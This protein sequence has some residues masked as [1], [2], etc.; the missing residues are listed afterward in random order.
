MNLP[1]P[2]Q[3]QRA[4]VGLQDIHKR[5][6]AVHEVWI[7]KTEHYTDHNKAVWLSGL[8][9]YKE[10]VVYKDEVSVVTRRDINGAAADQQVRHLKRHGWDKV[11]KHGRHKLSPY[12]P[13]PEFLNASTR[14]RMCLSATDFDG[15]K[16]SFGFRCATCGAKEGEP[17]PRYGAAFVKIQQSHRNPNAVGDV[18]DNIIPQCQFCICSYSNDFILDDKGR[19][20]AVASVQPVRRATKSVQR[21]ILTYFTKHFGRKL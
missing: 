18:P 11:T 8:W 13:S 5:Y 3:L 19:V 6:L 20:Y 15:I 7:P 12:Q 2:E 4:W 16:R 17:D 10:R 9:H 21:K 14:K 1:T